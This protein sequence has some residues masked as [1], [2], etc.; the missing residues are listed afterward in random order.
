[1]EG[2]LSWWT[3]YL[4]VNYGVKPE[5]F[6]ELPSQTKAFY[7]AAAKYAEDNPNILIHRKLGRKEELNV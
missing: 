4:F 3:A 7:I 1:M 5:E 2:S 6:F